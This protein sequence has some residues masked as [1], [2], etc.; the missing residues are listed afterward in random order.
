MSD[1][2]NKLGFLAGKLFAKTVNEVK[3]V[4]KKTE[5][6]PD[7]YEDVVVKAI[8][9]LDAKKIG[10]CIKEL[11]NRNKYESDEITT[12]HHIQISE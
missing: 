12:N 7:A 3:P 10:F 4:E 11:L 9:L 1:K 6:K 5:P 8:N 2:L